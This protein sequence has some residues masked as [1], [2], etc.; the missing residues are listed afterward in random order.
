[1]EN[2]KEILTRINTLIF[3]VDGVLTNGLVTFMPDGNALRSFNSKDAYALQLAV[4]KDFNVCIITGGTSINI[5]QSLNLLGITDIYLSSSHKLEVYK[6]YLTERNLTHDTILFMGDD[7]PDLPVMKAVALPCC[8]TDA[9]SDCKHISK[10]ISHHKGG[11]GCVRDIVEQVLRAQ[12]K[13]LNE[14][15]FSW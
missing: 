10:Y 14:D 7:I 12:N 1:M 3:D 2:Y 5:K 8:P 4:R 6:E 15:S 11:N 9:S 13:W